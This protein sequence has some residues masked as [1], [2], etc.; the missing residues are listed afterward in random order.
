[1]NSFAPWALR[2]ALVVVAVL[3]GVVVGLVAALVKK[4]DGAPTS[5]VLSASGAGF[6]VTVPLVLVLMSSAGLL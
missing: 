3:L 4:G 1:M 2:A 5:S 6:A